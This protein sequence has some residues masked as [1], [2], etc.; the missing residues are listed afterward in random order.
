MGSLVVL[1]RYKEPDA[2]WFPT[3]LAECIEHTEGS[4]YWGKD[5]VTYLLS[6]GNVVWTPFAEYKRGETDA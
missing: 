5:T 3:T 1:K 6:T 4:G 2:E